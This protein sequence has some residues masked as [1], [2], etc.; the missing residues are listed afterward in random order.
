M[1]QVKALLRKGHEVQ[2]RAKAARVATTSPI[3]Q[4]SIRIGSSSAEDEKQMQRGMVLNRGWGESPDSSIELLGGFEEGP[5]KH[6]GHTAVMNNT[7]LFGFPGMLFEV[8]KN[9]TVSC[10]TVY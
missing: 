8:L 6:E 5:S 3:A 2:L 4:L 9:D 1:E 10:L 7:E